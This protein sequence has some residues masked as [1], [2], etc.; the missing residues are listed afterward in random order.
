MK[1]LFCLG[2]YGDICNALPIAWDVWKT[3]GER[4]QFMVAASHADI[5]DGVSYVAPKIWPGRCDEHQQALASLAPEDGEVIN[6]M[7]FNHSEYNHPYQTDSYQKEAW[8]IAGYLEK[9]GTLP[10][11]F[12]NRT[13]KKVFGGNAPII[14]VSGNGIS[15]PFSKAFILKQRLWEKFPGHFISDFDAI[16]APKVYDMLN[17]MDGCSV[18]VSVD[19]VFL[20]LARACKAPVVS[21]INNGWCGSVPPPSSRAVFRYKDALADINAVVNAVEAVLK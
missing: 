5:L 7:I 3:T 21:I 2:R 15:S 9:F 10:L 17:L 16:R 20:H 4:P 1:T 19:T 6:A 18:I 14:G 11:V 13:P 12:D 8:R